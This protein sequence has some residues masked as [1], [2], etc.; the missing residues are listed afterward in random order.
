MLHPL[1]KILVPLCLALLLT[2]CSQVIDN[3]PA[4]TEWARQEH[5][6]RRR[7]HEDAPTNYE[8]DGTTSGGLFNMDKYSFKEIGSAFGKQ[9]EYPY[10]SLSIYR[11]DDAF[12]PGAY[13]NY[14]GTVYDAEGYRDEGTNA[15][16]YHKWDPSSNKWVGDYDIANQLQLSGDSDWWP[17]GPDIWS[18]PVA[19]DADPNV[20]YLNPVDGVYNAPP[21][22]PAQRATNAT[23]TQQQQPQTTTTPQQQ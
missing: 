21:F 12:A 8:E 9:S 16:R 23:A 3:T 22:N 14:N 6:E 7:V 19:S 4:E 15:L 17:Q 18:Y 2:G 11:D 13:F 20:D 5:S 1:S 10:S